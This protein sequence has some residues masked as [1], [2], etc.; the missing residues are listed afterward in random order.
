MARTPPIRTLLIEEIKQGDEVGREVG[1]RW[2]AS[3]THVGRASSRGG[4]SRDSV[5]RA[6]ESEVHRRGKCRINYRTQ[7]FFARI[8]TLVSNLNVGDKR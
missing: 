6:E 1:R 2:T 5:F 7:G 8:L 3:F 4:R